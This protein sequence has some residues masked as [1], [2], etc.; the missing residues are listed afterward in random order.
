[1]CIEARAA[2]VRARRDVCAAQNAVLVTGCKIVRFGQYV[3]AGRICMK[4]RRRID[5][6]WASSDA[7]GAD[8]HGAGALR[9]PC[10]EHVLQLE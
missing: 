5:E 1:M 9:R 8:V 3:A 6:R 2:L 7:I 10:G 4:A